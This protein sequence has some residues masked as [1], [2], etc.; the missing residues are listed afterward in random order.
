MNLREILSCYNTAGG[1]RKIAEKQLEEDK[2][3]ALSIFS[4]AN[5]VLAYRYEE[6]GKD[7]WDD[8]NKA[9]KKY[10]YDNR[11]KFLAIF[12]KLAGIKLTFKP[13]MSYFSKAVSYKDL[14]D[15]PFLEW[16][17]IIQSEHPTIIQSYF[18]GMAM[19]LEDE[20]G[21]EYPGFSYI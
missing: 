6:E 9:S 2:N 8:R 20:L 21:I 3:T 19:A 13:G 7:P 15:T 1:W 14:K 10:A 4:L 12:E 11:E 17:N 18:R 5:L 16:I